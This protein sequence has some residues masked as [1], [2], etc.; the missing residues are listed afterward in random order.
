M[1]GKQ[2]EGDPNVPNLSKMFNR[3]QQPKTDTQSS[4][5]HSLT[6]PLLQVLEDNTPPTKYQG[7]PAQLAL[8]TKFGKAL[9]LLNN[10]MV[11]Q[12]SKQFGMS[13]GDLYQLNVYIQEPEAEDDLHDQLIGIRHAIDELIR[14]DESAGV[15]GRAAITRLLE[16][17]DSSQ[18]V[19][20]NGSG[21]VGIGQVDV[22]GSPGK[23]VSEEVSNVPAADSGLQASL[24]GPVGSERNSS[25]ESL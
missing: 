10:P 16:S 11:S 9:A 13:G 19:Q 2:Q 7:S 15:I 18:A 8:R 3:Y 23:D 14:S 21:Q 22:G 17:A 12:L 1:Y 24:H 20:D 6:T 5:Q 25:Q 4:S